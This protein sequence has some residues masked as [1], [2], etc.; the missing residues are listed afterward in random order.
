[1]KKKKEIRVRGLLKLYNQVREFFPQADQET[2]VLLE[3]QVKQNLQALETALSQYGSRLE[4]L[5][6]PSRQAYYY[7]KQFNF[8]PPITRK[9]P[10]GV[11]LKTKIQIKNLRKQYQLFTH[12]LSHQKP[13]SLLKQELNDLIKKLWDLC[14]REKLNP[15]EL[16][17]PSLKAFASLYFFSLSDHLDQAFSLKSSLLEISRFWKYPVHTL[18][19]THSRTLWQYTPQ[20]NLLVL[21]EGFLGLEEEQISLF[22]EGFHQ[23]Q[24]KAF[25]ALK[26]FADSDSFYD[27]MLELE[28]AC[29]GKLKASGVF[30]Q[31]ESLFQKLNQK[32]FQGQLLLPRLQFN[33]T[34]NTRKL[35]QY[36]Y[37]QDTIL[38]ASA[39]DRQQV[40]EFAIGLVLYHEMLHKFLGIEYREGRRISHS[41]RF[42]QMEKHYEDYEKA[43]TWLNQLAFS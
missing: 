2:A 30:H 7:L 43:E 1:M 24:E 26:V 10:S 37:V 36:S 12:Q 5:P 8:S 21:N 3:L 17:P 35:G 39:L 9:E 25:T 32:Y 16:P 6:E 14:T 28:L 40:P 4:D 33:K 27:P 38:I 13:A 18:L 15:L 20:E 42:R 19:F 11:P 29:G 22:T 31:L 34:F 23:N 41:P